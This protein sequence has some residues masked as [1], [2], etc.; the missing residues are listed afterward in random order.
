[1]VIIL[2]LWKIDIDFFWG[3]CPKHL[4]PWPLMYG[5]YVSGNVYYYEWPP[6]HSDQFLGVQI[7]TIVTLICHTWVTLLCCTYHRVTHCAACAPYSELR[8]GRQCEHHL[9]VKGIPQTHV[10]V[11][12]EWGNTAPHR[13]GALHTRRC[14][15]HVQPAGERCWRIRVCGH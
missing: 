8:R 5:L 14:V 10:C 2:F 11:A 3:K 13:E 7:Y 12:Q 9:Y 6:P 1:M 4:T 15:T